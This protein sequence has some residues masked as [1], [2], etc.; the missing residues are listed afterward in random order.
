MVMLHKATLKGSGEIFFY[1]QP[2]AV[3]LKDFSRVLSF[4][5]AENSPEQG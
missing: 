4:L 1:L 2:L 5:R 3:V